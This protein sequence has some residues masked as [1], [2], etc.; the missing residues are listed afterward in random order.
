MINKKI[1]VIGFLLWLVSAVLYVLYTVP[2]YS[3]EE[4]QR[5]QAVGIAIEKYQAVLDAEW[6][7][8]NCTVDH[9]PKS[10]KSLPGMPQDRALF[11]THERRNVEQSGAY[12]S[13][14][15]VTTINIFS[16]SE[17]DDG[18]VEALTQVTVTKCYSPGDASPYGSALNFY[19][20]TLVPST[21]GGEY[22]VV[23]D[24]YY[25]IVKH[26]LPDNAFPV[27]VGGKKGMPPCS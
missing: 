25:D 9:C 17:G 10:S 13:P 1:V 15:P 5:F 11:T 21:I 12:V 7:D 8:E 24:V 27:Y 4:Q 26:P 6:A 22:V 16:V 2:Y 3:K 18:I 20:I 14:Q 19:K 23:D